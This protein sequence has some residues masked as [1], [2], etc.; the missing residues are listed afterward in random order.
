MIEENIQPDNTFINLINNPI[1][2]N[3]M[4]IRDSL[5]D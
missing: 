5:R 4:Q 1:K 3:S 2:T